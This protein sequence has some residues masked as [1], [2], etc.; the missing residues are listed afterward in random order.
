VRQRG[1]E[2]RSGKEGG[3]LSL[4]LSSP[5]LLSLEEEEEGRHCLML[6]PVQC[7]KASLPAT[8]C[9]FS[10]SLPLPHLLWGWKEEGGGCACHPPALFLTSWKVRRPPR[11]VLTT[12]CAHCRAFGAPRTARRRWN[13]GVPRCA[14]VPLFVATLVVP[15][16]QRRSVHIAPPP[17]PAARD[18][19]GL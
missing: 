3:E 15:L 6:P 10:L 16:H 9:S 17:P 19:R 13:W 12:V 4:C 7:E 14:A 8:L 2:W 18:A 5:L 11:V 1:R